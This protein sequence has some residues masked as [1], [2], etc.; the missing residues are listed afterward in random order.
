MT[1]PWSILSNV[2]RRMLPRSC[3]SAD[4]GMLSAGGDRQHPAA[5]LHEAVNQ[6]L[7]DI[8]PYNQD[9]ADQ[10][11]RDHTELNCASELLHGARLQRRG[12]DVLSCA[13]DQ[14]GDRQAQLVTLQRRDAYLLGVPPCLIVGSV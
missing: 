5:Q 1:T 8:Q 3:S 6:V 10:T 7:A 14:R 2:T 11:Q 13:V 12:I 9:R 4:R